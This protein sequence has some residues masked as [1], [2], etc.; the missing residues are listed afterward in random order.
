MRSITCA[1]ALASLTCLLPL[2][3]CGE[4]G[5]GSAKGP[6]EEPLLADG[7]SD[8]FT[9]PTEHGDLAF[10]VASDAEIDA[11]QRFHAWT[12]ALSGPAKISLRTEVSTNLDTVMY[13]Y[14]RE[15]G[16]AGYG[17]HLVK[18]DDY[19]GSI[20]SQIDHQATGP[21][22]YRVVVKPFKVSLS[23]SFSLAATCDGAGC[24][25]TAAAECTEDF[26]SKAPPDT[27]Y[28]ASCAAQ[29][30]KVL[31][32]PITATSEHSI[33]LAERCQLGGA[34][35]RAVE[36][37]KGYWDGLGAWEEIDYDDSEELILNL[38]ITEHGSAGTQI[39]VDA[40]GD[41]ETVVFVFD[42]QGQ[43]LLTFH[44]EQSPT[45]L[46][47]CRA[48]SEPTADA[49]SED[50]VADTLYRDAKSILVAS[51]DGVGFTCH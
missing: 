35:Q 3:G 37:Y 44:D 8:S 27:E 25:S 16:A 24:P 6:E 29:L 32:A 26:I 43:T 2:T 34:A 41:E 46:W 14:R 50:C 40:G 45:A 10:G 36:T 13:L 5:P 49:P 9:R 12:F 18:N 17:A 42:A 23:G 21:G 22:E 1:L 38:S 30:Q 51:P 19:K 15:P 7:K 20:W 33:T 11:S 47:G 28:G 39:A 4:A 48:A 31:L